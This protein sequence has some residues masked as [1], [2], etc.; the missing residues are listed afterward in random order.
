MKQNKSQPAVE[1]H[2]AQSSCLVVKKCKKLTARC[3]ERQVLLN[4]ARL[5][6]FVKLWSASES[7]S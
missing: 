4:F 5:K 2:F 6:T 1:A 3:M 7:D